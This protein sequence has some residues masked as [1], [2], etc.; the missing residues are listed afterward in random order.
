MRFLAAAAAAAVTAALLLPVQVR[1]E[2]E[3]QSTLMKAFTDQQTGIVYF[4]S[5][6][7]ETSKNAIITEMFGEAAELTIP[8]QLEDYTITGIGDRAFFGRKEIV[9]VKVPETVSYIGSYAFSGC[10]SLKT[11][12]LPTTLASVGKGCFFSCSALESVDLGKSLKEIPERCFYA[13][14]ALSSAEVPASV[15]TIGSEAFF[16]CADINGI[17]LPETVKNIGENAVGRRYSIRNS[18]PENISGF[19][20]QGKA[21]TAA[22]SYAVSCGLSFR[23]ETDLPSGDVDANGKITAADAAIVLKEYARVSAHEAPTLTGLNRQLADINGDGLIDSR[24]SARI[25]K[26][27]AAIQK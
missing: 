12:E 16:S 27:Y 22:E 2:E 26:E 14:T 6:P 8:S 5:I 11:A 13:C 19:V 20:I 21:G 9:S 23:Y 4:C 24:D 7:D 1:A 18:A 17:K 3:P 15:E 25:L 10:L